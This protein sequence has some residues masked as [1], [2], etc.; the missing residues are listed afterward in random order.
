M[1]II[2]QISNIKIFEHKPIIL[3]HI[4]SSGSNFKLWDDMS[5]NSILISI[6]G[7][8]TSLSLNKKFLKEINDGSVISDKKKKVP[9]YITKDPHCS[10]LLEPDNNVTKNWY[11]SHRFKVNKKVF[12]KTTEI[13]SLLKKYNINYIDWIVL[14]TQGV[15]LKIFKSI[16]NNLRNNISV[17]ELEPGFYDFYK[18]QEKIYDVFK[19]ME[20]Q[21][22]FEDMKFGNSFKISSKFLSNFEKKVM[23]SLNNA[24]KFYTNIT[25]L[26]KKKNK[27]RINLIKIIYMI[28]QNKY[29][30]SRDY[31]SLQFKEA[32]LKKSL[33]KMINKKISILKLKFLILSPFIFIKNFF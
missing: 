27:L 13:N 2:K 16:K 23:F 22:D 4:G 9:F 20:S 31:V 18:K 11:F 29:F 24:S 19:F 15:D 26:N 1:N 21:Y 28:Q 7:N 32:A 12:V 10:S 30:E 25:F 14:D 17:V 5:K 8:E 33:L 3:M 6:D